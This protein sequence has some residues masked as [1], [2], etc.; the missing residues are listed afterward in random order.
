MVLVS[1]FMLQSSPFQSH[2]QRMREALYLTRILD[3]CMCVAGL[4]IFVIESWRFIRT[5]RLYMLKC[6]CF[7]RRN[8]FTSP[9]FK[10]GIKRKICRDLGSFHTIV[11]F[12]NNGIT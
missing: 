7:V 12:C 11:M 2:L 1:P 6:V 4:F 5:W 10:N 9:V 8:H 3:V